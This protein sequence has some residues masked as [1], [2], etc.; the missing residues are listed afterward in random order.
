MSKTI[1]V[2]ETLGA[3]S[4]TTMAF[5]RGNCLEPYPAECIACAAEA[6]GFNAEV[7][8]RGAMT[9]EEVINWITDRKPFA[10]G[11]T[12]FTTSLS[13]AQNLATLIKKV[14]PGTLV[15]VGGYHPS[16]NPSCVDYPD[17]DF[18]VIGEGEITFQELLK[19]ALNNTPYE[20]VDGI[21]FVRDGEVIVT[22][23]RQRVRDLDTLPRPKRVREYL[24]RARMFNLSYPDPNHQIAAEIGCSRGCVNRCEFCVSHQMWDAAHGIEEPCEFSISFRSP[25]SIAKEIRQLHEEFGVNL[26][27]LTDFTFNQ[28]KRRVRAICEALIAEG[29]HDATTENDPDHTEKSVHWYALVKVGL[30]TETAAIMAAAGCAK[31]GTGI[32]SFFE[33]EVH[34]YNKPHRSIETVRRSLEATDK[35]GIINRCLL[36][37]GST[38]ETWDTVKE[39][40]EDLKA[41][42]V[43]QV[44]IAFLTPF[45]GTIIYDGIVKDIAD[46]NLDHYD[47]DIPVI[48]S[49]TMSKE[50]L[51]AA[52]QM[53]GRE[54]YGSKEYADRCVNKIAR[55]PWLHESY[56]WWF[57]DLY[58]R[59]IA[60]LRWIAG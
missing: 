31:V 39:T 25:E 35:A 37:F 52:R 56:R 38:N 33:A 23:P 59:G 34:N 58:Q 32:E 48:H 17:F 3:E 30:D 6:T 10:V 18:A 21:A 51:I 47:T 8:Q 16:T 22:K 27:Y 29:L 40:I 15:I 55:F 7:L 14:L 50:D 36:V 45:P 1:V 42:P 11:M 24:E 13:A 41:F 53:I 9:D 46:N 43:D 20:Q 49:K 44:R 28:D 57:N 2:M 19:A 26:L 5:T 4:R 12:V 54:L 60:D